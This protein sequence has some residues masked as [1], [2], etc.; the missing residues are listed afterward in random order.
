MKSLPLQQLDSVI[1]GDLDNE[2]LVEPGF[3]HR[4]VIESLPG[5]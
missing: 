4:E 2:V 3:R 5:E 1:A